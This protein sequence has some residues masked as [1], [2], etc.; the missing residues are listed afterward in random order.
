MNEQ[1]VTSI[2]HN[3]DWQNRLILGDSLMVE[4]VSKMM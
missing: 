4:G 2:K 1:P 3:D